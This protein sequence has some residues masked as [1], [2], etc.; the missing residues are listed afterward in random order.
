MRKVVPNVPIYI[1]E[2]SWIFGVSNIFSSQELIS[3]L[4]GNVL[5]IPFLTRAHPSFLSYAA[6]PGP[7]VRA[8]FPNPAPYHSVP[9]RDYR[10][11]HRDNGP[12]LT[13]VLPPPDGRASPR[14]RS[15]PRSSSTRARPHLAPA[16]GFLR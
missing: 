15:R 14:V 9:S 11:T 16:A 4:R 2:F 5:E 8:F 3:A 12:R 6:N 13:G 7:H 1:H 10:T